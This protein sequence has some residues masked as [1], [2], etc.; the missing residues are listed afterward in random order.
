MEIFANLFPNET[1]M[2][3]GKSKE[4]SAYLGLYRWGMDWFLHLSDDT[5]TG[6]F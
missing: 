2:L 1:E 4:F 6:G 3:D 5:L